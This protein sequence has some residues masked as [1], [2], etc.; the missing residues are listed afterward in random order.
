M[1]GLTNTS[2]E[3][4]VTTPLQ[5]TTENKRFSLLGV[6]TSMKP[7]PGASTRSAARGYLTCALR[8]LVTSSL[9][10]GY[11]DL[12]EHPLPHFDGR[13]P[14]QIRNGLLEEVFSALTRANSLLLSVPCYWGGV[15]GVFKNF[16]DLT[17]GPLYELDPSATTVFYRK[18]VGLFIV[19]ADSDSAHQGA[20]QATTILTSTGAHVVGDPVILSNPRH[21]TTNSAETIE[22]LTALGRRLV[23]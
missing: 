16:I 5:S 23:A 22:Q 10:I 18:P 9:R 1:D 13:T 8:A 6:C 15:S 19:G 3:R 20:L 2:D 14:A 17:C 11:L 21:A 12:R 4:E 7:A